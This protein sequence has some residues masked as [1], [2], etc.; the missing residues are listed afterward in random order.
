MRGMRFLV[1]SQDRSAD[2]Q[3]GEY[4]FS[5]AEASQRRSM[6]G[7]SGPNI[8]PSSALRGLSTEDRE[9]ARQRRRNLQESRRQSKVHV[10]RTQLPST[11]D[12]RSTEAQN[13]GCSIDFFAAS[14]TSSSYDVGS[15]L[16]TASYGRTN[17]VSSTHGPYMGGISA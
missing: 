8:L 15:N 4:T 2:L 5:S 6:S 3:S 1:R 17:S 16:G 10:R 14:S 9:V 11:S 12:A 7:P 13:V